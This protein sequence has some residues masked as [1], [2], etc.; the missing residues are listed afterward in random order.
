MLRREMLDFID[1]DRDPFLAVLRLPRYLAQQIGE[2]SLQEV[3]I[4]TATDRVDA[5]SQRSDLRNVP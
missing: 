1:C 2:V 5:H 3:R 4:G